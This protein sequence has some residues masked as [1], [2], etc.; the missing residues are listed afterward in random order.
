MK[1]KIKNFFLSLVT[2]N[3]WDADGAKVAGWLC[4]FVSIACLFFR[5]EKADIFLY[6]GIG[7]LTLKGTGE[8]IHG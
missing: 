3:S 5:P 4:I 8:A 7:A 6:S 1:D 2:D